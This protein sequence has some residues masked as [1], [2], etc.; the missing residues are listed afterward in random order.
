M[1]IGGEGEKKQKRKSDEDNRDDL[2]LFPLID[3]PDGENLALR[4][5]F[6]SFSPDYKIKN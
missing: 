3:V 2:C 6:F 5:F 4:I 1:E